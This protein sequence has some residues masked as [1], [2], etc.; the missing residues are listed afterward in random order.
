MPHNAYPERRKAKSH[1]RHPK[2]SEKGYFVSPAVFDGV[3]S[4]MSIAREEI[5][6][7]VL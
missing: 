7:P 2:P 5:L 1:A 3:G 6:D 4:E